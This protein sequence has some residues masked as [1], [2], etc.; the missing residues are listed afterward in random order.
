MHHIFS[1]TKPTLYRYSNC[2]IF[3]S[4]GIPFPKVSVVCFVLQSPAEV[5]R[6]SQSIN[7]VYGFLILALI[8]AAS[9]LLSLSRKDRAEYRK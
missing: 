4:V 5:P 6:E 8:A 2:S 3:L 9:L 1:Q 7:I